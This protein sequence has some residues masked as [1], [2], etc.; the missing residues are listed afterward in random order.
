MRPP[1]IASFLIATL[2]VTACGGN[3]DGGQTPPADPAADI[4][5]TTDS[6][7]QVKASNRN[8][9]TGSAQA[10]TAPESVLTTEPITL[11]DPTIRSRLADGAQAEPNPARQSAIDAEVPL[12]FGISDG[13]VRVSGII[14][15][16]SAIEVVRFAAT[17]GD[18]VR[19]RVDGHA[20][21][22]PVATLVWPDGKTTV[23]DDESSVNRDSRIVFRSTETATYD[24]VVSAFDENSIGAFD[25]VIDRVSLVLDEV[26]RDLVLGASVS[27]VLGDPEDIDRFTLVA[28]AGSAIRIEIDGDI[29]VDTYTEVRDPDGR[30]VAQND[31]GGHGLDAAVEI[32]VLVHGPYLIDVSAVNAKY[33][34]YQIVARR[35]VETAPTTSHPAA[36]A[37]LHYFAALRDGDAEGVWRL[38]G[39][40]ARV[41]WGWES[42]ADVDRDLPKLDPLR[43]AGF[44]FRTA[45]F[46]AGG[47]ARV[48]IGVLPASGSLDAAVVVDLLRAD[49][50]WLV[51]FVAHQRGNLSNLAYLGPAPPTAPLPLRVSESRPPAASAV[52]A[53]VIDAASGA[54]LYEQAA[55]N[56][57]APASLTKVATAILAIE[58]GDFDTIVDIDVDSRLMPSSSVMGLRPGDRFTVLDLLHGL[59]LNSGN[60]A[61]IAIGRHL[62]GSDGAFVE[63]LN[64]LLARLGL[65]DSHFTNAHGLDAPQHQASA[66]D[67]AYLARYAMTLPEFREIVRMPEIIARG[68]RD[69]R[70]KNTNTFLDASNDAIGVKSGYTERAHETLIAAVERNRHTLIIVLL[71][72]PKRNTDAGALADWAF[73]SH[74][75]PGEP[76]GT[77]ASTC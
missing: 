24:L 48:E 54:T 4:L 65:Q 59:L 21:M 38:V 29:G 77:A 27:G 9:A 75:W 18:L 67:L 43:A 23:N 76:I 72:A 52:G 5:T 13:S 15:E 47:R 49:A 25:V 62:A 56:P 63:Q 35:Q 30:I 41:L 17:S 40:E 36:D 11:P 44:P 33:G 6:P 12:A 64:D 68:S 19:I 20:G 66:L 70:L 7:R 32:D 61:A 60:D 8:A 42:A 37:A 3:D 74:C 53:V 57:L 10:Q 31:D 34:A 50:G 69:I 73:A 16:P 46:Q 22:D 71:N 39:P 55:R 2:L 26:N 58:N 28:V 51:E 14:S 1:V 45:T